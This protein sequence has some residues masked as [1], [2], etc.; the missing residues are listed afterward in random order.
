MFTLAT[1]H[2]ALLSAPH[3]LAALLN[4]IAVLDESR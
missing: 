2:A 1:G 3:E 4:V